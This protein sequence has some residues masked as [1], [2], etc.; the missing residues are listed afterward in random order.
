MHNP[1]AEKSASNF[2][3]EVCKAYGDQALDP[4][5]Q[6]PPACAGADAAVQAS[7]GD[8]AARPEGAGTK[9]SPVFRV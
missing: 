4:R 3:A 2:V 5:G 8:M 9:G 6:L 1:T 7:P